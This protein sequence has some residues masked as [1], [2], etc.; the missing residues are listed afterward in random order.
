MKI[1]D[2]SRS[3]LRWALTAFDAC[4][5]PVPREQTMARLTSAGLRAWQIKTRL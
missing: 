5:V 4:Y 3:T 2:W 1:L